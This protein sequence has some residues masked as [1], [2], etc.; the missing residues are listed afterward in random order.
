MNQRLKQEL[1]GRPS[2]FKESYSTI[3]GRFG[4]SI[5]EV[6]Q[7]FR[8][9]D[10]SQ[11]KRDYNNKAP[12]RVKSQ[13]FQQ[14]H[15]DETAVLRFELEKL[16]RQLNAI[17]QDPDRLY[18]PAPDSPAPFQDGDPKNILV[19]GDTHIPFER[20][21][22]LEFCRE[23]QEKFNCGTVIHIGD[24]VDMHFSS[25]HETNPDGFSAGDELTLSIS[26]LKRWGYTFPKVKA[27]FGNHDLLIQRQAFS[28]GLSQKWIRGFNEVLE[29]PGWEFDMEYIIEDVIY[30]HGTGTSGENG[31][32]Q[33][34][35]NRRKS[36]VSGHLH[37]IANVKWNVSEMDRIFAMQVGCGI[38][39]KAYAFEY[40]RGIVKKSIISCGVVLQGSLPI[41]IPMNL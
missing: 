4:V 5:D 40:A 18:K 7:T 35:L 16:R 26:K 21:G 25:F 32:F 23:Q 28:A 30:T 19:I 15:I 17:R 12:L 14:D 2:Y 1:L 33:K 41:I 22:Y 20:I 36:V 34:A 37:T 39:D 13:E 31:A 8:D 9:P 24:T 6:Y 29:L 3:A 11:A 38:D 10:L 27:C